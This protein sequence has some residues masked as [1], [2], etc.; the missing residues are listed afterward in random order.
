[1]GQEKNVRTHKV[2]GVAMK[3]EVVVIPVSDMERAKEFRQRDCDHQR[4]RGVALPHL[5]Q[6]PSFIPRKP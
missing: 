5:V 3:L 4:T 6:S 1:M 2:T